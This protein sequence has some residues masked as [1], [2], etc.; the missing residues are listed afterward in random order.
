MIPEAFQNVVDFYTSI[1]IT[2][3]SLSCSLLING[4]ES[5]QLIITKVALLSFYIC[6]AY[7]AQLK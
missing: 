1:N 7:M 3:D 6:S 2:F 5:T 4:D